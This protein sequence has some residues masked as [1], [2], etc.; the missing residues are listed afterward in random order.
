M[1]ENVPTYVAITF[2][3]T[4]FLTIGFLLSAVRRTGNEKLP[5][6]L[7]SFLLAFWVFFTAAA[8]IG[9]FYT[10]TETIPPRLFLL[11]VLPSVLTVIAYLAFF[12]ERF[13]E[14]FPLRTLTLLHVVRL[15]VE[16]VLFWLFKAALIPQVMTFEGRNFDILAGITAPVVAYLAIRNGTVNRPV[17]IAWN[18]ISLGLLLNIVVTAFLSFPGPMQQI[19]FDQPN[20]AVMYFPFI[21]LPSIVVPIVLFAHLITLWKLFTNRLK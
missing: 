6:Q 17:L 11:G 16:I 7:L 12:R 9:G 10:V 20:R 19:A 8:S 13:L 4:T 2:V 3:A 1:I 18:L 15:P 5:A 14:K 21:W